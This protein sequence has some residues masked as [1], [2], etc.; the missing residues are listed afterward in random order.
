ME[1]RLGVSAGQKVRLVDT[2]KNI[3]GAIACGFNRSMEEHF[4]EVVTI[5]SINKHSR[6][7]MEYVRTKENS[8]LWDIRF[9]QAIEKPVSKVHNRAEFIDED[10]ILPCFYTLERII[11][12]DRAVICFVREEETGK[13]IKTVSICQEGDE[14]DIH[15]G[16]EI[17]MYK[18]LRRIADKNLRKY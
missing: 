16:V 7:G 4:G 8:W 2:R 9:L 3:E 17:C 14:F 6:S 18:T 10:Y 13:V 11:E 15:R 1:N 12:N 5:L